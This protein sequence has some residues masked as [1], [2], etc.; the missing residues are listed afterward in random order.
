MEFL[1]STG[2]DQGHGTHMLKNRVA[3]LMRQAGIMGSIG[4]ACKVSLGETRARTVAGPCEP[5]VP[6]EAPNQLWVAD[7]TEHPT[8]EGKVYLAA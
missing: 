8:A 6:P 5:S 4:D 3:R 1:G 2:T 7:T